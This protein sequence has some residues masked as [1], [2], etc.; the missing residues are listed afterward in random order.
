MIC[1]RCGRNVDLFH[2]LS[3]DGRQGVREAV[4]NAVDD[5]LYGRQG[6]VPFEVGS[7][8][9]AE[10]AATIPDEEL[11]RLEQRV[12]ETLQTPRTCD[13]VEVLTGLAHQTAS[14]RIRGLVL[15]RQI[16]NSGEKRITRHNRR[17]VVWRRRTAEDDS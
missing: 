14:A 1:P 11:A 7:G 8:T 15:R 12:Y 17:A 6:D 3:C 5:A 10:A 16:I 13:E 4:V 2:E 9:S